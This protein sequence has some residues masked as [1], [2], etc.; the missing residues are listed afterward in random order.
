MCS[1]TF[2]HFL[3]LLSQLSASEK[4]IRLLSYSSNCGIKFRLECIMFQKYF[5]PHL[6][7]MDL[8]S[9]EKLL[10]CFR[11]DGKKYDGVRIHLPELSTLNGHVAMSRSGC[12]TAR[13][14]QAVR[15]SGLIV[16]FPAG[17]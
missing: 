16:V 7:S 1:L 4:E 6:H 2:L 11:R 14:Y 8:I 10:M 5:Y 9:K 17:H 12:F 15:R 13:R 3:Y